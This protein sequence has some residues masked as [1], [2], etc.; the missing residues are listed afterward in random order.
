MALSA[1][2]FASKTSRQCGGDRR[3]AVNRGIAKACFARAELSTRPSVTLRQ[4]EVISAEFT[5]ER[6]ARHHGP[7]AKLG[8]PSGKHVPGYMPAKDNPEK[9]R[10]RMAKVTATGRLKSVPTLSRPRRDWSGRA[11]N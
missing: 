10:M 5:K 1:E 8:R 11:A 6:Y 2:S 4:E 7:I 3:A 9:D